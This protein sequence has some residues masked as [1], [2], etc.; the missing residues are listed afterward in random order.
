MVWGGRSAMSR[1]PPRTELGKSVVLAEH[2]LS[3]GLMSWSRRECGRR[4]D[5]HVQEVF[6]ESLEPRHDF[7]AQDRG[8]GRQES[9]RAARRCRAADA[10]RGI[11]RRHFASGR[12]KGGAQTA[13]RP[14]L[15]PHHGRF[16]LGGVPAPRR[17]GPRGT[18]AGVAVAATAVG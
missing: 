13:A 5:R 9:R 8:T 2:L 6:G 17:R 12:G 1:V 10:R 7:G 3:M 16:V 11:C 4:Y 18:S 14:L 15:L